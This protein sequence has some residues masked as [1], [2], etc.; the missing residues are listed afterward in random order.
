MAIRVI[1][2]DLAKNVFQVHGVDETGRTALTRRLCQTEVLRLFADLQPAL[3]GMEAC[4]TAHYWARDIAATVG[5]ARQFKSGRQFAAWLG[6]V[7]QQ[8]S[9]SGKER[10]GGI[11][12]RGDRY[13]RSLVAYRPLRNAPRLAPLIIA[14]GVSM[15]LQTVAMMIWGREF[16]TYPQLISAAQLQPVPGVCVSPVQ[17]AT[18]VLSALLMIGLL[19]LVNRT[20]LGR[21]MRATAENHRV[22]G[23]MGSIPEGPSRPTSGTSSSVKSPPGQ[24][25]LAS[26]AV[27]A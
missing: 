9:S 18:V 14:I 1:G 25:H 22:A 21:A 7:P 23:L 6:L 12:K 27:A 11:S 13:I 16:H 10:L 20:K 5:D 19:L 3:V 24:H 4:H 15:L 17:V 8:R 26:Q 2:L